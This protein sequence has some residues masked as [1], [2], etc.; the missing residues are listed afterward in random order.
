MFE[1]AAIS[2]F[3]LA[4]ALAIRSFLLAVAWV[5]RSFRLVVNEILLALDAVKVLGV[6]LG[7]Y[8]KN[9]TSHKHV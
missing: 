3:L 7:L 8:K 6:E 1:F 5:I 4:A 9:L 2:A